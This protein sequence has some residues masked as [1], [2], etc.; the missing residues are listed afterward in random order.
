[1]IKRVLSLFLLCFLVTTSYAQEFQVP[2][3]YKLVKAEDY[4]KYEQDV[5]KATNWLIETPINAQ[6]TK[7]VEVQKFLF[8]W[9]QG[10]PKVSIEVKQNIVTFMESPEAFII[11]LG[12]WA[13]YCIENND[14][15]NDLQGNVRG[16][17][18]V[19]TFYNKNK[20]ELGKIKGIERYK[21]LQKKGKLESHLK[22]KL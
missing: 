5:I 17:E 19:I 21:R 13:S 9:L 3:N 16:I 6:K 18:N 8:M 22:S 14:Y 10:S 11:Y 12:G 7:R 4:D 2:T 20:K 15:K 1:M